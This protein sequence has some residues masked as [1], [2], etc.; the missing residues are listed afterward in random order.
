MGLWS[1]PAA[2]TP[3][4]VQ[5]KGMAHLEAVER[6]K[7][8]TRARFGLAGDEVVVVSEAEGTLPGCPAWETVVAFWAADGTR[9][10]FKV[11]KRVE[12]MDCDDLPPPWMKA[13]LAVHASDCPCC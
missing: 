8:W 1:Q 2:R 4:A 9:H 5:G 12:A 13:A 11:F 10:H 7:D 3:F 6:L